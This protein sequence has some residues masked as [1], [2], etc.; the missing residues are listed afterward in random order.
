MYCCIIILYSL[1][2]S[3]EVSQSTATKNI[4]LLLYILCVFNVYFCKI[5]IFQHQSIIF[6]TSFIVI[7]VIIYFI[8]LLLYILHLNMFLLCITV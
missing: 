3:A 8:D 4:V 2:T 7:N 5:Y 1:S 6:C